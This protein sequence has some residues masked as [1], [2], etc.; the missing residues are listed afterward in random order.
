MEW[1]VEFRTVYKNFGLISSR[2]EHPLNRV[3]RGPN[4]PNSIQCPTTTFGFA[5]AEYLR[6]T[7]HTEQF[8]GPSFF[9]RLT[10]LGF[11]LMSSANIM[12]TL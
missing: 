3:Q 2:L 5:M 8:S 1:N 9:P 10:I 11:L 7:N 4:G 6:A 12:A